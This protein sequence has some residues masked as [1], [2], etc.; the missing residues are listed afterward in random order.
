MRCVQ[1]LIWEQGTGRSIICF[2]R[3]V[4]QTRR[5]GKAAVPFLRRGR[6]VFWSSGPL[7]LTFRR[8]KLIINYVLAKINL[9]GLRMDTMIQFE[10]LRLQLLE[11]EDALKELSSALG[12][13]EMRKE[14]ATL[15]EQTAADGFWEDLG[16]SQKVLQRVSMLKNRISAYETLKSNFDDALV[17]IEL[18]NEEGDLDLLPECRRV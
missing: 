3:Q 13:E 14:V 4:D 2:S 9:Y 7:A 16:N 11:D 1:G 5:D 10:E 18:A 8:C 15:E 17:M 6:H 12:L